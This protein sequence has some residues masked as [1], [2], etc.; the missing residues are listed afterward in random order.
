MDKYGLKCL[1]C[2]DFIVSYSVHDFKYCKCGNVCIDGGNDY[3]KYGGK[4]IEDKTYKFIKV[5][6]NDKEIV[7]EKT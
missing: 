7:N 6:M 5:D 1:K 4:G 3:L 2:G